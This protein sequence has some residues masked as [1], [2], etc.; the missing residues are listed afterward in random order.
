MK[1][2]EFHYRWEW[3]L[4][5]S[6]EALW[7]MVADTNRFNWDAGLPPVERA[8]PDTPAVNARRSL[9]FSRLGVVVEWEEEPFE[10]VEGHTFSVVR[11]YSKGPI[12]RLRVHVELTPADSGGTQLVYQVWAL[13]AN[14]LGLLAIPLQIGLLSART[15]AAAFRS[16]DRR[17]AE[18]QNPSRVRAVRSQK[19][20]LIAGGRQRLEALR[21]RLLA[22]GATPDHVERLVDLVANADDLA[23]SQLRPY[24]LADEW[25]VDRRALLE[26]CLVATRVGLLEFEWHLLCPLCRGAKAKSSTLAG[27]EPQVHCDTCNIDFEVNFDRAVEITFHPNPS[28]RSILMG[29]F[30]IAGPR[31][32]PHVVLQQLTEPGE[33]RSIEADLEQGRYR[34]RTLNLAGGQYAAAEEGG[35]DTV[36]LVARD[37]GWTS[38]ELHV[39]LR[40]RLTLHNETS[41]EQLFI[42]ERLALSD[43]AVT[44]AEVTALQSFRDLFATEALRPGERISVGSLAVLFTDLYGSTQFYNEVGDA[45]AF[46]LVMTHFDVVKAAIAAEDGTLVKTMGDA[47]MAIFPRPVAALRSV[48]RAQEDL[49]VAAGHVGEF[50]IKAGIHFGACIAVT[51]NDRLDYFGSTVNI[52]SRLQHLSEGGDV[53]ISQTVYGDPEVA[54]QLEESTANVTIEQLEVRLK[55][56]DDQCFALKRIT[57]SAPT[58]P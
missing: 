24:E 34:L 48:L 43:Q 21:R 9:R 35:D 41:D 26:T 33:R 38:E 42:L 16:Y 22:E 1:D 51:M 27:V 11:H 6:P 45:T 55:G 57:P 19:V 39:G 12:R 20:K 58:P 28:L 31:V 7:P 36:D 29:E 50:R 49:A 56:F 37:S 3:Q 46:G 25:G 18:T 40:P 14:V 15:F 54:Q 5:S 30:C 52:A 4:E 44:G 23:A 2:R 13:P 17:T 53:V 32:T 47:V 8:D 10:W